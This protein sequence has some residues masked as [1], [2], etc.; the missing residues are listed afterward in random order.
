VIACRAQP[1]WLCQRLLARNI[2]GFRVRILGTWTRFIT[3]G[4]EESRSDSFRPQV[5]F[6]RRTGP[7]L[8]L[9]GGDFVTAYL[10]EVAK[11]ARRVP[12]LPQTTFGRG[13]EGDAARL[14]VRDEAPGDSFPVQDQQR[15]N[16]PEM[17]GAEIGQGE[18]PLPLIGRES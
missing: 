18:F 6:V 3:L 12:T 14:R 4:P 8:I 17:V 9:E 11:Q 5:A 16:R 10:E 2:P 13:E 7:V 1:P 15:G